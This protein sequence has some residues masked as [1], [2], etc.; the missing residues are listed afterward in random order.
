MLRLLPLALVFACSKPTPVTPK[1][2]PE[3][4]AVVY[5]HLLTKDAH[6]AELGA[7]TAVCDF[8]RVLAYCHVGNGAPG[9]D[10]F[11]DMRPKQPEPPKAEEKKP[12]PAKPDEKPEPKKK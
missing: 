2:A 8:G 3:N 6:C 11:A 10:A 4:Q 9:C 5:A 1:A 12:E 7:D